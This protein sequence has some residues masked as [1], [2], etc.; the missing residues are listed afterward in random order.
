MENN[1]N[2]VTE[3]CVI[4]KNC[5][6]DEDYQ[7]EISLH[8]FNYTEDIIEIFPGSKITQ[9][10]LLPVFY[11]TVEEIEIEHLYDQVSERGAGG[12]GSTGVH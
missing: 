4:N 2:Y 10:I 1:E 5:V 12:F 9:F 3:N 11:D 7:G 8:L 6:V